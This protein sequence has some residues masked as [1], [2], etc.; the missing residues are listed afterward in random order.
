MLKF[1]TKNYYF[2]TS[3]FCTLLVVFQHHIIEFVTNIE[4]MNEILIP[5][6]LKITFFLIPHVLTSD[7]H[8]SKE[9]RR[10]GRSLFVIYA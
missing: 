4:I 5:N 6:Y 1:E 8:L 7:I 3:A 2:K 9:H 10:T